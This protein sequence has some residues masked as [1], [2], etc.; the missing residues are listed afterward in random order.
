[1]PISA[2]VCGLRRRGDRAP[3]CSS[4][5]LADSAGDWRAATRFATPATIRCPFQARSRRI[6]A[7]PAPRSRHGTSSSPRRFPLL[8]GAVSLAGAVCSRAR[9]SRPDITDRVSSPC[10]SAGERTA[11]DSRRRDC[12]AP[13]CRGGSTDRRRNDRARYSRGDRRCHRGVYKPR[14]APEELAAEASPRRPEAATGARRERSRRPPAAVF[15]EDGGRAGECD[16]ELA[17]STRSVARRRTERRR[18]RR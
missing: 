12:D 1:M 3:W 14:R 17:R 9:P 6:L 5:W 16:A 8:S 2:F 4:R 13:G 18:L 15:V 11:S 10:F 7:L